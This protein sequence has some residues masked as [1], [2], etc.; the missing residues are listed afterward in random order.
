M[1]EISKD[2]S[3]KIFFRGRLDASKVEDAR[4]VLESVTESSICDFRDL[5]YISSAGLGLLLETQKRLSHSEQEL[6]LVNLNKSIQNIF[7]IAGFNVLFDM[8]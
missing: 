2:D 3:G 1:F 5:E 7:K 6:K 4:S 8:N